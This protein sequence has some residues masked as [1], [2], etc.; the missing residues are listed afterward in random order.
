MKDRQVDLPQLFSDVSR[1]VSGIRTMLGTGSVYEGEEESSSS[2]SGSSS[3]SSPLGGMCFKACG[4]E[5]IQYAARSA[6]DLLQSAR[7][8]LLV[9]TF[10]TLLSLIL[11]TSLAAYL[12]YR[13]LPPR[14][15]PSI[16]H[17]LFPDRNKSTSST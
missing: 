15:T 5:D 14:S 16:V 3:S 8:C 12:I 9:S 17:T 4:M 2:S 1:T 7:L 13:R 10:I 6:G 11:L